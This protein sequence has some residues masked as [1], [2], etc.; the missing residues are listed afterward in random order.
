MI[1]PVERKRKRRVEMVRSVRRA[2][3]AGWVM[4][5]ILLALTLSTTVGP[6]H[7]Q[8]PEHDHFVYLPLV[9]QGLGITVFEVT[10][11]PTLAAPTAWP[12]PR[13]TLAP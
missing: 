12:T 11:R 7:A 5:V 13:P 10:P 8:K 1:I 2:R 9:W 4:L 3:I 6:T